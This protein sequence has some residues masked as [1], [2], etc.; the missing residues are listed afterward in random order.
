M[1]GVR[2]GVTAVIDSRREVIELLAADARTQAE[3]ADTLDISRSTVTRAI[4]D[5]Q[6]YGLVERAAGEYR[7]TRMGEALLE[8]HDRYL[9][10]VGEIVAAEGLFEH[11]P[12]DAPFESWL[13]T[14]GTYHPV[15]PGAPFQVRERVNDQ[16]RNAVEITGLGR[17][18]SERESAS[19]YYEKVIEEGRPVE[20]V[21]SADLYGHIQSLEW[22]PEFFGAENIDIHV[23][24]SVP[25][26]LFVIDQPDTERM[27][28]IIYDEEDAMKGIICSESPSAIGWARDVFE[29]YRAEAVPA[30]EFDG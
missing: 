17:T 16:F 4:Q 12:R 21:L 2:E 13:L 19:V 1:T 23:H 14:E 6:E 5:L 18:R 20:N 9:E 8:S 25:Y 15:E 29:T 7:A 27:I 3:I 28:M 24:E 10:E 26:G 22:A 30:A 11:L